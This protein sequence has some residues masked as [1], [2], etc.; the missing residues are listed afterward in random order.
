MSESPDEARWRAVRRRDAAADGRFVYA[1]R[2]TGVYCRP[3]CPSRPARRENVSF[4][5]TPAAAEAAGF[6]PCRRCRPDGPPDTHADRAVREACER[7]HAATTPPDLATLALATGYSPAH[8]QRLF[9]ARVGLSPKQYALARRKARLRAALSGAR[10]VTDA[11]YAAGFS[12]SSRAYADGGALGMSPA[13]Y[14]KGAAGESIR[15]TAAR[16]SLGPLLVAATARGVC[17]IEFGD[18]GRLVAELARRFPR[19]QIAPGDAELAALVRRVVA[20]VEAPGVRSELPLDIRGTA[21]QE[22]VWRA[23]TRIPPGETVTYSELARRVGRPAAARAVA[24]ACA[25]NAL[26]VA[27][28][29]HRVVRR[30]GGA[31]GY[32]WGLARKQALLAR[33]LARAES[34]SVQKTHRE[35]AGRST[36]GARAQGPEAKRA[37]R[38]GGASAPRR[39][40]RKG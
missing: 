32:R 25:A 4:H 16:S 30:G 33:E 26:A 18:P 39:A 24:Q 19:A 20:L 11:I 8:F 5:G 34:T 23:L 2:T 28:P 22:R 38:G 21:F 31:S 15:F 14:R 13:R 36:A 7:I 9:K 12:A 40:A 27:V 29:C 37:A 6:R 1:V 10:S 3:S 17:M 35:A